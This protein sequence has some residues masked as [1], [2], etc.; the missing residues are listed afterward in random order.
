MLEMR[1]MYSQVGLQLRGHYVWKA[2]LYR[3]Y[4]EESMPR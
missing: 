4:E 2:F 1:G 3:V